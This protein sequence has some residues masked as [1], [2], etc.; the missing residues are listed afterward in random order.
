MEVK[1]KTL[2][3]IQKKSGGGRGGSHGLCAFSRFFSPARRRGVYTKEERTHRANGC[4]AFS[5]ASSV[6]DATLHDVHSSAELSISDAFPTPG[7]ILHD[8]QC[9]RCGGA[10][11]TVATAPGLVPSRL[12]CGQICFHPREKDVDCLFKQQSTMVHKLRVVLGG[13]VDELQIPVVGLVDHLL[14]SLHLL[15]HLGHLRLQLLP[16]LLHLADFLC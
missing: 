6:P 8:A 15:F 4:S 10:R 9:A 12:R 2:G 3:H 14:H 11:G 16:L 7:A 1:C 13:V 5:H